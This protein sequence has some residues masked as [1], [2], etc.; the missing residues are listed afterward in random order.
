M[1]FFDTA[2]DENGKTVLRVLPEWWYF[3]AA[4]IPLTAIIFAFWIW[5]QR[6]RNANGGQNSYRPSTS[7]TTERAKEQRSENHALEEFHA[8]PSKKVSHY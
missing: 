4:T 1:T 2:T 5:W 3:L 8:S 6:Q 7:I